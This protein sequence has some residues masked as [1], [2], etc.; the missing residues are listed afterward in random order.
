MLLRQIVE[1]GLAVACEN[2][3]D[4][5]DPGDDA[6]DDD[7]TVRQDRVTLSGPEHFRMSPDTRELFDAV[8]AR[9]A[10]Q[11]LVPTFWKHWVGL[12]EKVKAKPYPVIINPR[13]KWLIVSIKT[14][15]QDL[16]VP[17]GLERTGRGDPSRIEC[18]LRVSDDLAQIAD[19]ITL[20]L[21][22]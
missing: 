6:S 20:G 16:E 2:D 19:L 11:G 17:E 7:R 14:W 22:A 3:T 12:A 13:K 8:V 21:Q 1:E 4:D 15:G 5:F 10:G 18:Y 9:C